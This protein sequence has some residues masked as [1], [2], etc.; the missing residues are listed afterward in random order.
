MFAPAISSPS[1]AIK[2]EGWSFRFAALAQDIRREMM[3]SLNFA[4]WN[5]LNGWLRQIDEL[6]RA[7]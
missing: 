4:S 7:A 6:R 5:Q 1:H 3:V 2:S